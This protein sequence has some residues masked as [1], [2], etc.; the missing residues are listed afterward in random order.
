MLVIVEPCLAVICVC[1]PTIAPALQD[2]ASYSTIEYLKMICRIKT[3][4]APQRSPSTERA[5]IYTPVDRSGEKIYGHRCGV[6]P[7]LESQLQ[8]D[9]EEEEARQREGSQRSLEEIP[10]KAVM[11]RG[12]WASV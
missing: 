6:S 9:D 8:E 5:E 2:I 7:D 10:E 4:V 12:R 11:V 1:L 3:A